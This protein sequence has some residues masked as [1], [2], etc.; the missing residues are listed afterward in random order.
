VIGLPLTAQKPLLRHWLGV[1]A[2]QF[3]EL[4]AEMAVDRLARRLQAALDAP[5]GASHAPQ[6]CLDALAAH[7]LRAEME[8]HFP[9]PGVSMPA[10]ASVCAAHREAD[11][12]PTDARTLIGLMNGKI[13]LIFQHQER[14]YLLDYKG[15]L[16]GDDLAAYQGAALHDA[17]DAAHY[18]FQALLYT[19]ALDRYLR[20]RL[21]DTYNR[22][23]HL[24]ECFYLFVR[25]AGL[26]DG[27]GI[28]RHRFSDALLDAVNTV[29]AGN[30]ADAEVA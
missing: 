7:A 29:L 27:A 19:V 30:A 3:G 26:A 4:P 21:G 22:S 20:Q 2:V 12:V 10:L 28:W 11:L 24:G 1:H 25:A 18:R 23:R 13:D 8:F 5:L 16:L 17:M 6:L 14:F 9:L 15:N